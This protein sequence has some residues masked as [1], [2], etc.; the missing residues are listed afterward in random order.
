MIVKLISTEIGESGLEL[1]YADNPELDDASSLL[2]VR[3]P[4]DIE[5]D[6]SLAYTRFWALNDL[7]EFINEQIEIERKTSEG[8]S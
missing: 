7:R 3:M 8:R 5:S 1:T 2:I 4:R 6:K